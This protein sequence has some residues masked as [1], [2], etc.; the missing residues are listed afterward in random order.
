M[1]PLFTT[2]HLMVF[3]IF[4]L[5]FALVVVI[6]YW[7]ILKKAGFAPAL[8]LLIVVP[9]VNLILLYYVAFSDWK[10]SA[11]SVTPV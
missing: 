4:F 7:Q 8:S 2:I 6:P 1:G 5:G 9:L 3:L 10:P 11:G